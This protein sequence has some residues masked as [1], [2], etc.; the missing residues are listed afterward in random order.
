MHPPGPILGRKLTS[1]R[2]G[3]VDSQQRPTAATV[4]GVKDF[5]AD[6]AEARATAFD[7]VS[8][9]RKGDSDGEITFAYEHESLDAPLSLQVLATGKWAY[10]STSGCR[11]DTR[12]F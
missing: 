7:N 3:N 8:N 6:L 4:M 11:G 12:L 2:S 5:L 1:T 9:I 10:F